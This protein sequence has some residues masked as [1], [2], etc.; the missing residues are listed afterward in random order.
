MSKQLTRRTG[1]PSPSNPAG[2]VVTETTG[3]STAIGST[4]GMRG[5]ATVSALMAGMPADA[6]GQEL[7][8]LGCRRGGIVAQPMLPP[9]RRDDEV[10]GAQPSSRTCEWYQVRDGRIASVS[11]VFDARPFAPLYEA[12]HGG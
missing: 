4:V 2:A 6:A 8:V 1:N 5:R 10:S 7:F 12:E 9:G 3:R 11:A